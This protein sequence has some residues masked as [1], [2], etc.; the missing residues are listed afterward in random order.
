L[1]C[2]IAVAFRTR[3]PK[4][5]RINPVSGRV[6]KKRVFLAGEA[7]L[8]PEGTAPALVSLQTA[9]RAREYLA[10]HKT[11]PLSG[12]MLD[13]D[14]YLLRGGFVDCS[15]CGKT[16]SVRTTGPTPTTQPIYRC[17][18][19]YGANPSETR[20][21]I[22]ITTKQLDEYVWASFVEAVAKPEIVVAALQKLDERRNSEVAEQL[23]LRRK[24]LDENR[25][26]QDGLVETLTM[27]KQDSAKARIVQQLD[28]LAAEEE[29]MRASIATL[30]RQDTVFASAQSVLRKFSSQREDT[31]LETLSTAEKRRLLFDFG[32]HVTVAPVGKG[33]YKPPSERC[34]I[35]IDVLCHVSNSNIVAM[36]CPTPIHM[37]ARP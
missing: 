36:P 3:Q 20:H 8:L 7:I 22:G 13:K 18:P 34:R 10:Q 23:A 5:R 6:E 27:L 28:M 26:Q 1:Y 24:L 2:G 19:S 14:A 4:E 9:E 31:N 11:S 12:K 37:V 29:R 32:V 16:M 33:V 15:V 30:E 35:V 21:S 25:E 17:A